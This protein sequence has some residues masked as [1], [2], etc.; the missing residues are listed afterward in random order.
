MGVTIRISEELA[1]IL[2]EER[3]LLG[4]RSIEDVILVLIRE[5]RRRIARR[6]FGVD[7]GRISRFS[8]G[9]RLDSRV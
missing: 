7:R 6:F 3:K 1:R 2:E 9:D 5:R 4:V 8:E